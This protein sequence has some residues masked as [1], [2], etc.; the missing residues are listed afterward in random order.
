MKTRR[1][2]FNDFFRLAVVG[3]GCL[4]LPDPAL[5]KRLLYWEES[6]GDPYSLDAFNDMFQS[7]VKVSPFD[8]ATNEALRLPADRRFIPGEIKNGKTDPVIKEAMKDLTEGSSSNVRPSTPGVR[9]NQKPNASKAYTNYGQLAR[10]GD[11]VTGA[12]IGPV[13]NDY[14]RPTRERGAY[15]V[16]PHFIKY[17]KFKEYFCYGKPCS[18]P[19]T[20]TCKYCGEEYVVQSF[21]YE[22]DSRYQENQSIF[23]HNAHCKKAP[24]NRYGQ[25]IHDWYDVNLGP[26]DPCEC[27]DTYSLSQR[28]KI[29]RR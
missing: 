1:Q 16:H 19:V 12:F 13:L 3:G 10:F 29:N 23:W 20:F 26:I 8:I 6:S 14:G 25:R 28:Q 22:G 17:I 15:I 21:Y 7:K 18:Q 24:K 11:D 5:A 2:F 9:Y 4:I 27:D